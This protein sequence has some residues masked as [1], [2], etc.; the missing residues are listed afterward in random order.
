MAMQALSELLH[1]AS[2]RIETRIGKKIPTENLFYEAK[3]L[4]DDIWQQLS[5]VKSPIT[6]GTATVTL[7]L[8]SGVYS[9]S[10]PADFLKPVKVMSGDDEIDSDPSLEPYYYV[11][12]STLKIKPGG[13]TFTTVSLDYSKTL[14]NMTISSVSL[15]SIFSN[16]ERLFIDA[17]IGSLS[18]DPYATKRVVAQIATSGI[19]KVT[20][21]N[22]GFEV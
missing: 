12:G 17:L 22:V 20:S 8:S 7:T 2:I 1:E 14:T 15:P 18:G 16:Y 5:N 9:G 10:L 21:P 19:G 11:D 6:R 13:M 4:A 3:A